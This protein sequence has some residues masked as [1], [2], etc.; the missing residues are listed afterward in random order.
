[1][2]RTLIRPVRWVP[3]LTLM[4]GGA[5]PLLAQVLEKPPTNYRSPTIYQ[6]GPSW[7]TAT[8]AVPTRIDLKWAPVGT[9]MLYR[10]MRSTASNP[11]DSIV[12]EGVQ[13]LGD[14][15]FFY[16]D[17]L[18][19]R[20]GSTTFSYKV[21]AVFVG[22]DGSRT[23]SAPSP[24]ATATA[25]PVVAPKNLK[26]RV[27]VSQIMGRLRVTLDWGPVANATG[28]HVFQITRPGTPQL[29]MLETTVK[30]TSMVIDNVVPGQGGTVCVVT[31]Y[32]GFLK[33]DTVRSC[34][35]VLTPAS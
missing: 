22:T 7:V 31:V 34:D 8:A 30:Q 18:P 6:A 5:F 2:H 29:P 19:S 21:Y 33:D 27:A 1:V 24:T 11:T 23:L 26:W 20:S 9:T 12:N 28:Y 16:L 17:Y 13:D 32:E 3:T 35:L 10:I 4:V 25:L 14:K 15:N